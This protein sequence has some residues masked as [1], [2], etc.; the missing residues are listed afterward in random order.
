MASTYS[1]S[2]PSRALEILREAENLCFAQYGVSND[3]MLKIVYRT[4]QLYERLYNFADASESL[5]R[6]LEL[7]A[8]IYGDEHPV[9]ASA[10][11][12][13]SRACSQSGGVQEHEGMANGVDSAVAGSSIVAEVTV[14]HD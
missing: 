11:A 10:R 1:D 8:A 2:T 6:W 3:M 7:T 4:A 14:E 9:T 13:I 12:Q 5:E